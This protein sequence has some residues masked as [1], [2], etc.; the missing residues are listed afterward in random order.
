MAKMAISF[1]L[2]VYAVALTRSLILN[3]ILS[4]LVL[5]TYLGGDAHFIC[6]KDP[7]ME[8]AW[9]HSTF[10]PVIFQNNR[11]NF[12]ELRFTV[13]SL[14]NSTLIRCIGRNPF[15]PSTLHYSNTG[16]I[17]IQGIGDVLT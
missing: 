5:T 13:S 4:P 15:N 7:S 8:I 16:L 10:I 14:M 12:S 9:Y 3:P 6:I 17:V 1:F 2:L 11:M